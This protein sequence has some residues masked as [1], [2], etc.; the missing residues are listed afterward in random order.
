MEAAGRQADR[1]FAFE[2]ANREARQ[3]GQQID[4]L[5]EKIGRV[6]RVPSL[7]LSPLAGI[8]AAGLLSGVTSQQRAEQ[9][10]ETQRNQHHT[11]RMA[12]IQAEVNLSLAGIRSRQAAE[13]DAFRQATAEG[14]RLIAL[15]HQRVTESA[16]MVAGPQSLSG[17]NLDPG[18]TQKAAVAARAYANAQR[19]IAEAATAAARAVDTATAEDRAYAITARDAAAA[20]EIEARRMEGVAATHRK[21][22]AVLVDTGGSLEKMNVAG[23]VSAGAQRAAYANLSNQ[24]ADVAVQAQMGTNAFTILLQQ[25]TQASFAM[26]QAGGKLGA[27]GRFL[28]NPWV[29]AVTTASLVLGTFVT[30]LGEASD[31]SN[32]AKVGANA[33]TDAQSVLGT[34]FDLTSG[35]LE[36]QNEL[37]RL[38]ARLTAINLRAEATAKETSSRAALAGAREN[39]TLGTVSRFFA[40]T[41][42]N[43]FTR[44]AVQPAAQKTIDD[45]LAKSITS[46]QAMKALEKLP[47][48][49]F[50][51]SGSSKTEVIQALVDRATAERNHFAADLIDKTLDTG[52]LAQEL[53][54]KPKKKTDGRDTANRIANLEEFGRDTAD[55]IA[56]I[57]APF[58]DQPKLVQQTAKAMRDLADITDD[59]TAK[60]VAYAKATGKS[61]PN[62]EKTLTAAKAAAQVVGNAPVMAIKAQTDALADQVRIQELLAEGRPLEAESL[63]AKLA[64]IRNI[65]VE[66]GKEPEAVASAL[67]EYEK[68]R[69]R[70]AQL[71]VDAQAAGSTRQLTEANQILVAEIAGNERLAELLARRHSIEQG[72]AQISVQQL[73][74]LQKALDLNYELTRDRERR[75]ALIAVEVEQARQLQDA[76]TNFLEDPFGKNS[77]KDLASSI[78]DARRKAFAQ[79]MSIKIFGD[80][81]QDT[82][83][84]LR[85]GGD[86]VAKAGEDLNK[87]ATSLSTSADKS[88]VAHQQAAAGLLKAADGLSAA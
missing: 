52:V 28:T 74:D 18:S 33:L 54:N 46:E 50:A 68:Q 48:A 51:N 57:A 82:E 69:K 55:R 38:N 5:T 79:E 76:F 66:L 61:L 63:R 14:D 35:K 8:E 24:I 13:S 47:D 71:T 43:P 86:A 32:L 11:N 27:I 36:N 88:L 25:G 6:S 22:A 4:A 67:N 21:V 44:A 59:L 26:A 1:A 65:G 49:L 30:K 34:M 81:G 58:T 12:A 31:A 10:L 60:N 62:Y 77:L 84:R 78:T 16:R 19:D 15:A 37:L 7:N 29:A 75:N 56:S 80:L 9:T 85:R 45:L 39:S 64:I 42:E 72:T 23:A 41:P 70:L 20:A 3:F 2:R 87:S 83:D 40:R 53:R 17:V 73:S